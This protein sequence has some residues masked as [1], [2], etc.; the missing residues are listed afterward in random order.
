M[1]LLIAAERE[2]E[3]ALAWLETVIERNLR[4]AD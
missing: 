2:R 4:L 3:F 1:L